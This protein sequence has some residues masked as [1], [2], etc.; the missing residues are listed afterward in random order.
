MMTI[1]WVVFTFGAISNHGAM[2]IHVQVFVWV[3]VFKSFGHIPKSRISKS[4]GNA[5]FLRN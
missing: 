1:I 5:N 2:N 3:Y 4:F